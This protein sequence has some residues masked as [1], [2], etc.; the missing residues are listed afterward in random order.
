M[1]AAEAAAYVRHEGLEDVFALAHARYVARGEARGT[2]R[3]PQPTAAERRFLAE[4][5]VRKNKLGPLTFTLEQLDAAL[6]SSSFACSLVELLEAL[7]GSVLVTRPM[8]KQLRQTSHDAWRRE[9]EDVIARLPE[10]SL[11]HGWGQSRLLSLWQRFKDAS[12]ATRCS[13]RDA[14]ALT[15]TTLARLPRQQSERLA[16]FAAAVA[17]DPHAFDRDRLAGQFLTTAL[18][19]LSDEETSRGRPTAEARAAIFERF[20]LLVDTVWSTVAAF[21]LASALTIEGRPDPLVEAAGG[22]VLNLASR[23]MAQWRSVDPVH[24]RVYI[25]ENPSVFET[26]VDRLESL[27]HLGPAGPTLICTAGYFTQ[28]CYRLIDLLMASNASVTLW[29]SGDFDPEG[30]EIA[31]IVLN[32]YPGR[33]RLWRLDVADYE[34]TAGSGLPAEEARLRG[35]ERVAATFPELVTAMRQ[36]CVWVYQETLVEQLFGDVIA[37]GPS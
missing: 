7:H 21:N 30:L 20:G 8:Q 18:F 17:G 4:L 1:G 24:D 33:T 29:Y 13:V 23:Q 27:G 2:L 22:R 6:R 5:L 10:D 9:L 19:D 25:V 11:A 36:K 37:G 3:L 34:R 31:S 14:F 26:L 12:T 16:V 35:L 15:L 28:P 32:R